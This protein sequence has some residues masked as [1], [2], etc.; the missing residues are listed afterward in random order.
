MSRTREELK[1]LAHAVRARLEMEEWFGVTSTPAPRPP[2]AADRERLLA[3]VE[4]EAQACRACRLNASRTSVVFGEGDPDADIL[5][6][7]EAPGADEDRQGRP[8][9]GRA[10]KLLDRIIVAMGLKREEVYIAN[11]LKCRPP[12]NRNPQPDEVACC[13]PFLKRQIEIIRPRIIVSLGGVCATHLLRTA[14]SVGRLRGAFHDYQGTPVLVTYH[15]AYL[16]RN[17]S[18]KAMVWEDMKTVLR[19]LGRPIPD[20][21]RRGARQ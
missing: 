7:G 19:A 4:A 18:A 21:R 5:F 10:G 17:P 2:S 12:G 9:V 8:F 6:I 13:L 16:L 14:E 15:P 1:H 11:V 20:P 3:D